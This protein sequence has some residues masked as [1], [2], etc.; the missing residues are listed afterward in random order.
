MAGA[1]TMHTCNCCRRILSNANRDALCLKCLYLIDR[2]S[3]FDDDPETK[4]GMHPASIAAE[5]S[6]P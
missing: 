5:A 6:A 2:G 4:P 1:T 3:A